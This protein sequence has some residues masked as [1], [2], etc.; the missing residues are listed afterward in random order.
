[1]IDDLPMYM[2]ENNNYFGELENKADWMS[3]IN[4]LRSIHPSQ[5]TFIKAINGGN[6]DIFLVFNPQDKGHA[7]EEKLK[8]HDKN[9]VQLHIDITTI[10]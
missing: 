3:F 4:N 1:M 5:E 7:R 10:S 6:A 9:E 8:K 2:I